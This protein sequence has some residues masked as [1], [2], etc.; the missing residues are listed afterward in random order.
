M[1]L[2]P[3]PVPVATIGLLLAS[4]I[5]MTFAWY[6]HLK[7]KSASLWTVIL[8]SWGIAFLEYC[9]QVPANRIGHGYFSAVELKTIQEVITLTVFAGFSVLYLGE[10]I[11]INHVIGFALIAAG[12]FFVF[13]R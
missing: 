6:G 13:Q 1:S 3:V 2:V 9:F 12:A 4:N 11:R 5:F 10:A 7:F 8:A